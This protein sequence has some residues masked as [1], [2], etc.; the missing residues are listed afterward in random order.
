VSKPLESSISEMRGGTALPRKNGEL[1]FENPWEARAFGIAVAL[2]EQGT[3]PWR[4]FSAGLA[5][6]IGSAESSNVDSTYYERW[7]AS[8]ERLAI[9]KGLISED[10]LERKT[11]EITEAD[12]HDHPGTEQ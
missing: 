11:H 9:A 6:E 12:D 2:N 7:L 4:D 5:N 3:Y 10:E 8:L 1:V